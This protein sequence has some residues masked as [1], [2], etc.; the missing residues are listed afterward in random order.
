MHAKGAVADAETIYRKLL[1]TTPNDPQLL[2]LAGVAAFQLG[3]ATEAVELITRAVQS[4][5]NAAEYHNNLATVL[6]GLGRHEDAIASYRRAIALKPH[7][8]EAHNNLAGTL[9]AIGDVNGAIDEYQTA[10]TQNRNYA[11]AWD[12]Y[13]ST[14]RRA[15]R[16]EDALTAYDHAIE[17]QPNFAYAHYNR[18]T[19]RLALG[20]FERG[21]DDFE[22]RWRCPTFGHP[23]RDLGK[24]M[25]NGEDLSGKTILFHS[26]QGLGDTLHFVRYAAQLAD[27]GARVIVEAQPALASLLSDVPGVSQSLSRGDPLPEFDFHIPMM[28]VPRIVGTRLETI[29]NEMPYILPPAI[30]HETWRG[31]LRNDARAEG[32]KKIRVGLAWAGNAASPVDRRR[33]IALSMLAP[34]GAA[35]NVRFYSLQLGDASKQIASAP[36]PIIDHTGKLT[37]FTQTSGLIANLDLVI[38]VDTVVAHLAGA[39][40]QKV[41]LLTYT[42]A[43]WRWLFDREDS[44]WYPSL[45]LFRQRA[46][47]KWDEPIARV[48][49]ELKQLG[50]RV[51][52]APP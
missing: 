13:G 21:W 27:R 31:I 1:E 26:E 40:N 23:N 41:W 6:D 22:W 48:A 12:N 45:K 43:D 24:P 50:E 47:E 33:S 14:L 30:A 7:Y 9:L 15:G 36:F 49:D 52:S 5:P 11:E 10:I 29:P 25:W 46:P 16:N 17:L 34:L 32:Q 37:D 3:R 42:P 38:C 35:P 44:P 19:L 18:G 20:D 2:H 4:D 8:P 28:S 39:M 51:D